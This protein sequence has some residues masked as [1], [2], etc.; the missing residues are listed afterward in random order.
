[1]PDTDQSRAALS[2]V[3]EQQLSEALAALAPEAL[4]RV[5]LKTPLRDL[6]PQARVRVAFRLDATLVAHSYRLRTGDLHWELPL[7]PSPLRP[8]VFSLSHL[9]AQLQSATQN[10]TNGRGDY[11][12]LYPLLAPEQLQQVVGIVR[13][14]LQDYAAR[15]REAMGRRDFRARQSKQTPSFTPNPA[16]NSE[17]ALSPDSA[18][19]VTSDADKTS[20]QPDETDATPDTFLRLQ[21]DDNE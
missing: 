8:V 13:T 10:L 6:S 9:A 4:E 19:L 15:L 7:V 20:E 21:A 3:H 11:A 16:P 18:A 12:R 17:T 2:E 14:P 1:M 5:L